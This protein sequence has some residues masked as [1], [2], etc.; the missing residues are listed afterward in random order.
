LA[1]DQAFHQQLPTT[2]HMCFIAYTKYSHHHHHLISK[3]MTIS[4]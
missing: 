2:T 4:K 3:H 1:Q